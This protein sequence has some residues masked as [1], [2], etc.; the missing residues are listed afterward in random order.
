MS[1]SIGSKQLEKD[2]TPM[3]NE[4]SRADSAIAYAE[5]SLEMEGLLLVT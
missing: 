3:K 1:N 2:D 4:E 5:A